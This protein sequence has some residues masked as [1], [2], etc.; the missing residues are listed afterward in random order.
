MINTFQGLFIK[1][2]EIKDTHDLREKCPKIMQ[3][4][5]FKDFYADR[6]YTREQKNRI[7]KWVA[8]QY[9]PKS[10]FILEHNN[11]KNRKKACAEAAGFYDEGM[12]KDPYK[13]FLSLDDD[14]AKLLILSY[15]KICH[16][17]I[18]REIC[19]TEQ[20]L[21]E[22]NELRWEKIKKVITTSTQSK[23]IVIS[24]KD[25]MDA[26]SKKEKLLDACQKRIDY[27]E[28]LYDTFFSDNSDLEKAI[29]EY[30]ITPETAHHFV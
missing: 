12:V 14:N 4:D 29:N 30:P 9:D 6:T 28:R 3:I 11:L 17:S 10:P 21:E 22:L 26:A 19:T 7:I 20:E 27:L 23:T 18:W 25:I 5:L 8:F 2:D 13:S 15:L 24:D 1:A 16:N